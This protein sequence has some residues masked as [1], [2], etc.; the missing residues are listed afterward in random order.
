MPKATL[1]FKLPE[2]EQELKWAQEGFEYLRI[3]E[4]LDNYLRSKLKYSELTADQ[5]KIYDEIRTELWRLR[6]DE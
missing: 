1:S 3:V 4:D 2:E 5:H 6:N